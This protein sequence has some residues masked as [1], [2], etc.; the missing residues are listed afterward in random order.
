MQNPIYLFSW[1]LGAC[2]LWFLWTLGIKRLFMDLFRERVFELRFQLFSLGMTNELPFDSDTYRTLET[3]MCGLLRFGHR[4]TFLT[5]IFSRLEQ[6][7]AKKE[8]DYVD[9]SQQMALQISR[10]DANTQKKLREILAGVHL[11]IVLFMGF[12]SLLF[13]LTAAVL[14]VSKSLGLWRSERAEAELSGVIEREAYRSEA[15]RPLYV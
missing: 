9:V 3:L 8:K 2:A 15:R 11:A 5:F 10:L 4:I 1:V 6:N 13:L 12:T 7:E 14:A